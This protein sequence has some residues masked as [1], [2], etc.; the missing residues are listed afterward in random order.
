MGS[1]QPEGVNTFESRGGKLDQAEGKVELPSK[2][3]KTPAHPWTAWRN[4]ISKG[5]QSRRKHPVSGPYT[6][7][8]CLPV[9]SKSL[10]PWNTHTSKSR[11]ITGMRFGNEK[12]ALSPET[13]LYKPLAL[14]SLICKI[15]DLKQMA[16]NDPPD[17][18]ILW[19]WVR[20]PSSGNPLQPSLSFPISPNASR[21]IKMGFDSQGPNVFI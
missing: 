5:T 21:L 4:G 18:E 6:V 14:S 13:S 20:K 2:P 11:M 7:W 17:S 10:G 3:N 9:L 15:R 16:L 1:E 12:R 8:S 19:F